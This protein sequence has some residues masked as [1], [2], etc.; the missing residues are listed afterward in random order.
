MTRKTRGE[1]KTYPSRHVLRARMTFYLSHE[2]K[3]ILESLAV[4]NDTNCS[5]V[6]E[7]LLKLMEL[8][9]EHNIKYGS[10]H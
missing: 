10:Q 2:T 3:S 9:T 5:G 7:G 8:D 4:Q 6:I 1:K